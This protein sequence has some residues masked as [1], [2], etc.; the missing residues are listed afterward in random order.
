MSCTAY[1]NSPVGFKYPL[2]GG[3]PLKI[4]LM[5]LIRPAALVPSTF[6]Y[7]YHSTALAGN[8]AIG[9]KIRWVGEYHVNTPLWLRFRK[10]FKKQ[11]NGLNMGVDYSVFKQ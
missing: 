10:I 9:K 1:P 7:A 6:V 11:F 3:E 4:E 2:A 8:A 5:V